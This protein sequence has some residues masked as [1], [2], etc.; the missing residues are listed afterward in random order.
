MTEH[1][2]D[3]ALVAAIHEPIETLLEAEEGRWT[4]VMRRQ[5]PHTP[6]RLW[7]MLTEPE[8]L[9]LWSPIVPNRSLAT[10]G[11]ATSR[12]NP[13][14]APVDTE[15][16]SVDAPR[17]LVH[18]WRDDVLRWTITPDRGGAIVELRQSFADR[19]LSPDYAAGWQVCLGRLA[20]EDGTPRERPTGR[21][22]LAYGW[23]DLRD[24]YRSQLAD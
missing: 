17:E 19:A 8:R 2:P 21:R 3:D 10:V 4:L 5:F 6:E 14:D 9:A 12:E 22:A 16:L 15:V 24:G 18:R 20:A 7:A 1:A 13:G 23:Q 11:P